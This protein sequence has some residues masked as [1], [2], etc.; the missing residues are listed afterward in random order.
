MLKK[1]QLN[2]ET[3]KVWKNEFKKLGAEGSVTLC[4]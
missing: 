1:I 4:H 2:F 3:L